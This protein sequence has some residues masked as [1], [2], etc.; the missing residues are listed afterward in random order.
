MT[1]IRLN[2]RDRYR[3]SLKSGNHMPL[4]AEEDEEAP[5]IG[6]NKRPFPEPESSRKCSKGGGRGSRGGPSRG[7]SRGVSRGASRGT[8][9]GV[10][11]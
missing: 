1:S 4:M 11:T 7:A 3:H 6:S 9:R 2:A 5:T 10:K 8:S